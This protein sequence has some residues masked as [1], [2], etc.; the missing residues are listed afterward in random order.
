MHSVETVLW[1]CSFPRLLINTSHD[2]GAVAASHKPW[3]S[4]ISHRNNFTTILYPYI[5]FASQY[6]RQYITRDIQHYKIG[7]VLDNFAQ[8]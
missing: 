5:L 8:L 3:V 1:I 2:A 7:F 6:G 4:H